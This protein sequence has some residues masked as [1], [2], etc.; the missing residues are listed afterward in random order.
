[1]KIFK[2]IMLDLAVATQMLLPT[3]VLCWLDT[4]LQVQRGKLTTWE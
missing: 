3:C 4:V 2:M 1:M